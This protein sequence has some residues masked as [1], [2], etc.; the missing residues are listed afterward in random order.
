MHHFL[1]AAELAHIYRLCAKDSH[2]TKVIYNPIVAKTMPSL[3]GKKN[4]SATPNDDD[5]YSR[6]NFENR[7]RFFNIKSFVFVSG[8]LMCT[9]S[10]LSMY[11]KGVLTSIERQFQ[12]SSSLSG[13]LVGSFNVGNVLFVVLVSASSVKLIFNNSRLAFQMS[14]LIGMCSKLF[15]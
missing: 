3:L 6:G 14:A 8:V 2:L 7:R 11:T 15:V 5:A 10:A 13:L 1:A 9:Q 4:C 12:I